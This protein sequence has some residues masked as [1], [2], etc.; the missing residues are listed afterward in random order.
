MTHPDILWVSHWLATLS[1]T[2]YCTVCYKCIGIDPTQLSHYHIVPCILHVL[3]T[4]LRIKKK[5]LW[6]VTALC[7]CTSQVHGGR[8]HCDGGR[9]IWGLLRGRLHCPC[10]GSWFHG[11]LRPQLSQWV[12]LL[13]VCMFI[14]FT[15]AMNADCTWKTNIRK[16]S[17]KDSHPLRVGCMK[18]EHQQ[19]QRLTDGAID[20]WKMWLVSAI[21]LALIWKEYQTFVARASHLPSRSIVNMH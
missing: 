15:I 5:H 17:I 16:T 8:H 18:K 20:E 3:I 10:P 4:M 19:R 12:S 11:A 14:Y 2:I 1:A 7:I 21:C 6:F 9:D 13:C